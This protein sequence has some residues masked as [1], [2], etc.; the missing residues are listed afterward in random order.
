M[1]GRVRGLGERHRPVGRDRLGL[2]RSRCSVVPRCRVTTLKRASIAVS[3]RTGSSQWTW[4]IPPRAPED[5][6]RIEDRP[7]AEPEVEDHERLRGRDARVDHR[8]QLGDRVVHAAED[9][10]ARR[11]SRPPSQQRSRRRN[12]SMPARIDR[13][14]AGDE[15]VPGLL[16]ARNVVVPPNAAATESWKNRSGSASVATR[17]WVW[18]STTPGRTSSPVASTT[19]SAGAA[20]RTGRARPPRSPAANRD[21]GAARLGRGDDRPAPDE[22]VGHASVAVS[23]ASVAAAITSSQVLTAAVSF[24][25]SVAVDHEPRLRSTVGPRRL[26]RAPI[27]MITTTMIADTAIS[28]PLEIRP[29]GSRCPGRLPTGSAGPPPAAGP[30]SPRPA[31]RSRS[32]SRPAGRPWR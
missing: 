30:P 8:R 2:G 1:D 16:N 23:T 28:E 13:C 11:R 22:Q 9:R 18:T 5:A 32:G 31:R 7:V 29:R 15:P 4:S 21:V 27:A 6:H 10:R 20:G 14:A 25:R 12:S 24:G 26:E 3:I 17:V 19:S